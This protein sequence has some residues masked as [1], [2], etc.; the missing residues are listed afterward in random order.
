MLTSQEYAT[1][2]TEVPQRS[3]IDLLNDVLAYAA[4]PNINEQD[5][6][7]F[8]LAYQTLLARLRNYQLQAKQL[9]ILLEQGLAIAK[10]QIR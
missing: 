3:D 2:Q 8:G 4:K 9:K 6:Y 1:I 5:V 7:A 10:G